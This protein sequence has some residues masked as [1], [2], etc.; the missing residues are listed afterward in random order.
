MY[1]AERLADGI[2]GLPT[3]EVVDHDADGAP[4]ALIDTPHLSLVI[5]AVVRR[6]R[7][8]AGRSAHGHCLTDVLTR[9]REIYHEKLSQTRVETGQPKS[10][11]DIVRVKEEGLADML[12]YDWYTRYSA[13]DHFLAPWSDAASFATARYGELSDFVNQP[14][15]LLGAKKKGKTFVVELERLAACTRAAFGIP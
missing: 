6:Q 15:T 1:E 8:R 12:F 11:H 5:K 9:R 13:L 2:L 7:L 10:I 4:E 14:F 3:I